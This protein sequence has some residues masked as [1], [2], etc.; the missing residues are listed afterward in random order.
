MSN[1]PFNNDKYS[2]D[3]ENFNGCPLTI[4]EARELADQILCWHTTNNTS[5]WTQSDDGFTANVNDLAFGFMELFSD[6]NA[7]K[8]LETTGEKVKERVVN[9][10]EYEGDYWKKLGKVLNPLFTKQKGIKND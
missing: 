10:F 9:A 1:F 6:P 3:Y 4:F 5:D 8:R 2:D 7:I